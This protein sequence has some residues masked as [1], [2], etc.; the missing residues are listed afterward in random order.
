MKFDFINNLS[1]AQISLGT[2]GTLGC[3]ISRQHVLAPKA[4]TPIGLHEQKLGGRVSLKKHHFHDHQRRFD[5]YTLAFFEKDHDLIVLSTPE[6]FSATRGIADSEFPQL[7]EG[8]LQLGHTYGTITKSWFR[9]PVPQP[10]SGNEQFR[11]FEGIHLVFGV[12]SYVAIPETRSLRFLL[13]LPDMELPSGSPVFDTGGKL[14]GLI[15]YGFRHDRYD[16]SDKSVSG[17][18][19]VIPVYWNLPKVPQLDAPK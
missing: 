8:C 2:E 1:K 3:A 15:K 18:F 14:C 4:T 17:T 16:I 9:N 6:D 11:N 12:C 10:S 5:E 19:E 7:S 13:H